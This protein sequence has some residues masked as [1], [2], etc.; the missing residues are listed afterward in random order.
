[1]LSAT[2]EADVWVAYF[3]AYLCALTVGSV[4]LAL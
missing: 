2:H 3:F 1:M 4:I